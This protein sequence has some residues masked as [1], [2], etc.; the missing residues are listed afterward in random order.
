MT[1]NPLL[2]TEAL[3]AELGIHPITLAQWRL[4][5][6]KGPAFVKVGRHVRYR[7]SDIEAWLND[8]TR[9]GT[10]EAATQ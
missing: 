7:R 4:V 3:A 2:D 1:I 10:R 9:T 6:G 8:Q 5:D